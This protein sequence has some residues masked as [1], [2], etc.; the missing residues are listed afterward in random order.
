MKMV[1]S[2]ARMS[3]LVKMLRKEGKSIGF[4]PTMGY[5]HEGHLSMV[6]A[7]K[8]HTDVV[9]MSIFVNPL[10]FGP[11]EDFEKYPRDIKNDERLA[12][13][14]GADVIFCPSVKEMY[15]EGHA[16]FVTVE[17]LTDGLCGAS[18]P[19]H[20]RGVTTV[21]AKL[22]GI[23]KPD[24][25][26]FGQKDA[27]Q[28]IIIKKMV[29]DLHIGVEIKIMPIIRESDGLAMSSRNVYLS[30]EERKDA[31]VLSQAV[32][33][34]QSL[35]DAGETDAGRITS[36]MSEFIAQK[37]AVKVDYIS[38]VDTKDLKDVKIIAGETLIAVAAQVGKTR[39]IDNV[40]VNPALKKSA[41]Q[42]EKKLGVK[43]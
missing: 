35:F 10:Q 30:A 31:L 39:L 8:K 1:D 20:F 7:A 6:K 32:A 9:V 36:V 23:V 28:A 11:Q 34:A 17:R 33:K 43:A 24:V 40:I 29:Q 16:T 37:P 13:E 5:L 14:A 27:Q 12:G 18:R 15:P 19:G 2:I 26:Y 22:F 25:A 38:I 3:T 4:V 42:A 41:Q 21:V